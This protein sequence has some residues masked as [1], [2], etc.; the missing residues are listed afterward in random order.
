MALS[1]FPAMM[2][3]NVSAVLR[4]ATALR[5]IR[6]STGDLAFRHLDAVQSGLEQSKVTFG[7][8]F[9]EAQKAPEAATAFMASI[10]GPASLQDYGAGAI[11]L[12][13]AAGDWNGRLSAALASIPAADLITTVLRAETQTR[14]IEHAAFISAVIADPLRQSP[15]LAA[16]I[17]AFESLGG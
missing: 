3:A 2:D 4:T 12:E 9:A 13:A 5:F 8:A 6:D 7:M 16:L 10:G 1:R 14:H 17:A 15:E 11:A